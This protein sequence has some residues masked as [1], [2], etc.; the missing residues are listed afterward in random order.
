MRR[1]NRLRPYR[2]SM[3]TIKVDYIARVEG[4]GALRI[5]FKGSEVRDVELRIFEP[6]RFFE[7]F[8]RGRSYL[9][10]PDL[11]ARICGICPVAYQMSACAAMEDA[12]GVGIESGLRALRTLLYCGEWIESHTLHMFLL[13][14][15]DFLHYPDATTMAR[16]HRE[17]VARGL[18]IKKAGNALVRAVGGRE[19]HP[20]NVCVGGFYRAPYRSE[21]EALIPE[22][23]A[24]RDDALIAA[25]WMATFDF[26]EFSRDYELVA[27]RGEREYPFMGRRIVSNKGLNLDV[28]QYDATFVEAQVPYS[29]ALHSSVKGRGSYLCGPLSRFS[30]NFDLLSDAA[31]EAAR[32]A[33]IPV[34]CLNPYK[35]ILVRAVEVIHALE[36]AI[37][38][39]GQF[40]TPAESCVETNARAGIGYGCTEAPR[41]LLYHRYSL[42][43][44][45]LIRDAKIVPPT[46]QNQK[47]IEE[48][49][50]ALAPRMVAAAHGE[51]TAMAE[52]AIRN[53]D[54]CISCATH[55]LDLT[56]EQE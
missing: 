3:K 8:L 14:A 47:A 44:D 41:G 48:D 29:N 52:H 45:G 51:A 33:R 46:S 37:R 39:I 50:M 13:H 49:L 30:L 28:H 23:T 53:Y 18:R 42:D 22:L 32:R 34:P 20:I 27:I 36:E 6:P 56:M 38:I 43:G 7:A 4:E 2:R 12:I 10:A 24:A 5:R 40:E 25:E 55:F 35:S 9:E 54:P 21:L 31:R 1:R 16:D 19:V 15:P 26:P 17:M 11:T